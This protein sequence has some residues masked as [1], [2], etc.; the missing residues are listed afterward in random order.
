MGFVQRLNGLPENATA[1]RAFH[2]AERQWIQ[3]KVRF[4]RGG[5]A[6]ALLAMAC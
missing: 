6:R 4:S 1:G 2:A 3:R 5:S